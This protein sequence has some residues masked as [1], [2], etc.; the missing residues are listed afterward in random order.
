V[1]LLCVSQ[2]YSFKK[3]NRF[4]ASTGTKLQDWFGWFLAARM[5]DILLPGNSSSASKQGAVLDIVS[6]YVQWVCPDESMPKLT[7]RISL[8][9][10]R[11]RRVGRTAQK[12]GPRK[13][14]C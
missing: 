4:S 3:A 6:H 12:R 8:S 5:P 7:V 2:T 14:S 10:A 13:L 9:S 1:W 11:V